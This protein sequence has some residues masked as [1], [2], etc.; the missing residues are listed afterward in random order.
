MNA[1]RVEIFHVAHRDA[2]VG[3]VADDLI[4]DFFPSAQVFLDEHL[5]HVAE[6]LGKLCDK[7]LLAAYDSR[8]LAAECESRTYHDGVSNLLRRRTCFFDIGGCAASCG[9]YPDFAELLYEKVAVFCV[10]YRRDGS[11]E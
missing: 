10:A 2:V 3:T 7:F 4:L 8:A 1:N 6:D 9:F 5:P 11:T